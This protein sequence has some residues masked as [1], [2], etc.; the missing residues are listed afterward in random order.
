MGMVF[1]SKS[2]DIFVLRSEATSAKLLNNWRAC[3]FYYVTTKTS[4]N[5]N[6]TIILSIVLRGTFIQLTQTE[7][8]YIIT[9]LIICLNTNIENYYNLY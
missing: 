7:P 2:R 3:V 1:Y 6:G 5:Y 8:T 9:K 4:A